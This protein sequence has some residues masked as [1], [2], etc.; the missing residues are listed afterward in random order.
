[1]DGLLLAFAAF[2]ENFS[3]N[4]T[5]KIILPNYMCRPRGENGGHRICI[6][7]HVC[8]D[9]LRLCFDVQVV[10]IDLFRANS[11]ISY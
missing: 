6:I 5:P 2:L 10:V 1:M 7:R 4:D 11:M 8:W 3:R 9:N